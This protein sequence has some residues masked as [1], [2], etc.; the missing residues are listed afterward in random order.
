MPPH[1]P[2]P[3]AR[4]QDLALELDRLA[5]FSAAT[6]HDDQ[7]AADLVT[8]TAHLLLE[9]D[10][11][12]PDVG[13]LFLELACAPTYLRLVARH[14][15][16]AAAP[17]AGDNRVVLA[18]LAASTLIFTNLRQQDTLFYLLARF[19]PN[20]ILADYC[21]DATVPRS[22]RSP[23]RRALPVPPSTT[24][25]NMPSPATAA[26]T[27]LPTVP[28]V[29]TL[30][31]A[32]DL[33][34]AAVAAAHGLVKTTL[35]L[36][37][38][39]PAPDPAP[40]H[41]PTTTT[42]PPDPDVIAALAALL[43]SIA[44]H[45]SPDTLHL[46]FHPSAPTA[47]AAFPLASR[48]LD[49]VSNDNPMVRASMRA[50]VLQILAV[51]RTAED[52]ALPTWLG[53]PHCALV[54]QVVSPLLESHDLLM[55]AAGARELASAAA[56]HLDD[57][58][59]AADVVAEAHGAQGQLAGQ[60][61]AHV[62]FQFIKHAYLAARV[63]AGMLGLTAQLVVAAGRKGPLAPALAAVLM[64]VRGTRFV[65]AL[66][67]A[68]YGGNSRVPREVAEA[69]VPMRYRDVE[70]QTDSGGVNPWRAAI[71]GVFDRDDATAVESCGALSLVLAVLQAPAVSHAA[72]D[73]LGFIPGRIAKA[74][75]LL[76]GLGATSGAVTRDVRR[77]ETVDQMQAAFRPPTPP[78]P[79]KPVTV[80]ADAAA[81][82]GPRPMSPWRQLMAD[83]PESPAAVPLP[84]AVNED[85]RA[86]PNH[87]VYAAVARILERAAATGTVDRTVLALAA[88][89]LLETRCV[90]AGPGTGT[91]GSGSRT[92]TPLPM[93]DASPRASVRVRVARAV[94]A[95]VAAL[96]HPITRATA[97]VADVNA[98]LANVG[99]LLDTRPGKVRAAAND[100]QV[101]GTMLLGWHLL[102]APLPFAPPPVVDPP[103]PAVTALVVPAE[104]ERRKQSVRHYHHHHHHRGAL[105]ISGAL[106]GGGHPLA[107]GV[108]PMVRATSPPPRLPVAVAGGMMTSG[109]GHRRH[110][111]L[112]ATRGGCG[113][114]GAVAI[115][116]G[117]APA[118]RAWGPEEVAACV[119]AVLKHGDN[120]G[121]GEVV[122]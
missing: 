40:N 2:D 57:V 39:V 41:P 1:E 64:N 104:L 70:S 113:G 121:D 29:P 49:L 3:L 73:A 60:V 14:H 36:P 83:A 108:P 79:V 75:K 68:T 78:V 120:G 28:I 122:V 91:G 22:P 19:A 111:S 59:F 37:T 17:R 92:W 53:S 84:D 114:D 34:T 4:L 85:E 46:F 98:V 32:L 44:T 100:E 101:A 90:R 66:V 109:R 81:V 9:Y 107:D 119:A 13:D 6:L 62:Y 12:N 55:T 76:A 42:A 112:D 97:V 7:R 74:R 105:S 38:A 77:G 16:R 61:A 8:A 21:G 71:F 26:L 18:V 47:R 5:T 93:A 69:L 27:Y 106:G 72:F 45:L 23:R 25:I 80:S 103:V 88:A 24:A 20:A 94:R 102:V 95:Y 10:Q 116:G 56:M 89:V 52:E 110:V 82:T 30:G 87:A 118:R 51:A 54:A 35:G 67:A 33:G 115:G 43:R 96:S 31:L 117:M 63:S 50:V 86:A 65:D 11:R 15:H 99:T 58:S 48:A